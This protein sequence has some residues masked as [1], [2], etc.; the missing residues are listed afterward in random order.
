MK[1]KLVVSLLIVGLVISLA[2][3]IVYAKKPKI[4]V[5]LQDELTTT[6]TPLNVLIETRT[7]DYSSVISSIEAGGGKVTQTFK[8]VKGLSAEIPYGTLIEL[9][10]N[11]DV[12]TM[13]KDEIRT[14]SSSD[15]S[16]AN[17]NALDHE[18]RAGTAFELNSENYIM[19]TLNPM[20]ISSIVSPTTYANPTTMHAEEVW[21]T[22]MQMGEDTLVAVIDTG[23]YP[24]HFMLQGTVN[25]GVDMSYDA[26][27][28]YE[29]W[30]A[31][32]NHYHG[33]HVAGIIGGHG[34][35]IVPNDDLLVRSIELHSET[36]LP[37]WDENNDL[38]PLLGMAPFAEQYAIKVFDHTGG[39]VPEHM[40]IAGIEHA[41]SL[42]AEN[43][44]DVDII[45]MSL[46]GP[47]LFDG[48]DWEDTV[49]DIASSFGITVVSS[50][51]N[52]GPS[53]NTVGSP[54]SA[55]T[56][57]TVAAAAHP[58]NTRVFWDM[59][60]NW[61]GIGNYLYT[62]DDI[63]IYAFSS[64][65]P[66]S[67]GRDKVDVSATGMFVLSGLTPA[68]GALGWAS[69][70]SMA[71]PA[72]SGTVA[73]LNTWSERNDDLA[74]PYDYKQAIMAG[75]EP[76]PFYNSYEQGAG[77]LNAW[78]S[79][80]FL[81]SDTLGDPH[82]PLPATYPSEAVAPFGTEIDINE[83]IFTDYIF[84]LAPGHAQHYY[85]MTPSNVKSIGLKITDV[86]L[87]INPVGLNSFEV[88]IQSGIRTAYTYYIDSTNVFG[89]ANF[90]VQDQ[91][92]TFA[93]QISGVFFEDMPIQNGWTKIVI[94]NDWTSYWPISG[95]ME[96][97]VKF[98]EEVDTP[99]ITLTG[100][101]TNGGSVNY[102]ADRSFENAIYKLSWDT[103]WVS[104]PTNDL[105]LLVFGRDAEGYM[106]WVDI[107]GGSM[108]SPEMSAH[109]KSNAIWFG[110]PR[111]VEFIHI[112]VDGYWVHSG[113]EDYV[114]EIKF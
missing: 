40:I 99:D 86:D 63:Q 7:F 94:E 34:G 102:F 19:T 53:S 8:Y 30:G 83:G 72:V 1:K 95:M 62:T 68:Y 98:E 54:G 2:M 44:Y 81:I 92:T 24:D 16:L 58:I 14:L 112:L 69:G 101:V 42:K 25:D 26:G 66:T 89:T 114:L 109:P 15:M 46:G 67:D 60:Y 107:A 48:R 17:L 31:P 38:I 52:E 79:Y 108:N 43:I 80:N 13:S 23:I 18:F 71:C 91:H 77:Y 41:I 105:D 78:N 50:S 88:Y 85:F 3:P 113:A 64:R 36:D 20:E 21:N 84:D 39:G 5:A 51:G 61:F 75:A 74:T 76:I 65:G 93:G 37:I 90:L 100:S 10:S 6:M 35:I 104:Y 56:A 103:N 106:V 97:E 45:S 111:D 9:R 4:S 47:T 27:T 11:P 73:L 110:H 22:D 33:T 28:P 29:G 96:L 82:P 70:T 32:W 59:N 87:G 12:V 57:I 55:N 49:V